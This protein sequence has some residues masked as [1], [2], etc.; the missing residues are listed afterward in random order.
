LSLQPLTNQRAQVG[1]RITLECAIP[2]YTQPD[3][4]NWYRNEVFIEL[5]SDYQPS[6]RDGICQLTIPCVKPDHAGRY[7]CVI[8]LRGA[9]NSTD[10]YLEVV[11]EER[12]VS[13]T[14]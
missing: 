9:S 3:Q 2:P 11:P 4:V 10:M 7:T 13:K 12:K 1:Q 6:Y 14:A 8:V 5:S